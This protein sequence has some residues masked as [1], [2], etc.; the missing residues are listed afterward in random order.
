M[1]NQQGRH[2]AILRMRTRKRMES[3]HLGGANWESRHLGGASTI[4]QPFTRIISNASAWVSKRTRSSLKNLPSVSRVGEIGWSVVENSARCDHSPTDLAGSRMSR[5]RLVLS[6]TGGGMAVVYH[7]RRAGAT[8]HAA[9]FAARPAPLRIVSK[10][11][12]PVLQLFRRPPRAQTGKTG[13]TCFA[14]LSRNLHAL[15]A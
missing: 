4:R 9:M 11:V 1:P 5:K 2:K 3:R 12:R 10:Q 13:Q 7:S 8:L 6:F 15:Y 14:T